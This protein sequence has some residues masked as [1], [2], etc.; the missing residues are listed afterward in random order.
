LR[1]L[2]GLYHVFGLL[3]ANAALGRLRPDIAEEVRSF[4]HRQHVVF[5]MPW[6]GEIAI[7]RVLHGAQDVEAAF[8]DIDPATIF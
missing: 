6:K 4:P 8:A 2:E 7:L 1:Y 3:A 5:Y